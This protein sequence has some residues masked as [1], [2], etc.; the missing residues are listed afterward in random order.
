M[1]SQAPPPPSLRQRRHSR[2][3]LALAVL[4]VSL[5]VLVVAVVG[6]GWWALRSERGPAFVLSHVPG[7]SITGL[8]GA[9]DGGPLEAARV[10]WRHGGKRLLIEGLAWRDLAWQWRP[11]PGVWIGVALAEPRARRVEWTSGPPPPPAPRK[12]PPASLAL[13][14]ELA[15]QGLRVDALQ[16]D[17]LPLVSDLQLDAHLGADSGRR[18]TV[19][20]LALRTDRAQLS[21]RAGVATGGAQEVQAQLD[22]ASPAGTTPAWT[23]Q[24]RAAG[25][26][27]R[28]Q[29]E[30]TLRA[31]LASGAKAGEAAADVRATVTPFAAWPLAALEARTTDL[32]L[33]L[34]G[35]ALPHTRLTGR[36]LVRSSAADAPIEV[37]LD[38]ANALPGRWDQQR[39]PLRSGQFALRGSAAARERLELTRLDV[40]LGGSRPAGRIGGSGQWLADRA[41]LELRLDA[42][43]PRELDL[44]AAAM[45]VSGPL[46]L[47]L[48]GLPSPAG[49]AAPV[50]GRLAGETS[51]ELDGRI[52]RRG[53]PPVRL[54]AV[55]AFEQT[56]QALSLELRRLDASAAGARAGG[57]ASARRD[58]AGAWTV[59]SSGTLARFD[60]LPW[61]PGVG[62]NA[63]Q[64]G[65]HAL[66]GGWNADLDIAPGAPLAALRGRADLRIDASRLAGVALQGRVGFDGDGT[67]ARLDADLQAAAN[68]A[69]IEGRVGR[70]AADDRWRVDLQAPALAALAPWATLFDAAGAWVPQAG[71]ANVQAEA[72]GRWPALRSTGRAQVAGLRSRALNAQ[73]VDARW[74]VAGGR[75]DAPLSVVLE[76]DAVAHGEQ[77]LD[78]LRAELGGS[79]AA[80]TLALD[81]STPLR[82]PA[83]S[84]ALVGGAAVDGTTLAL[85]GRG[86]WSP[87]RAGGGTWRGQVARI[88][89]VPRRA[90]ATPQGAAWVAARELAATV[91]LDSAGA[92]R[93]AALAPGRLELLGAALTWREAQW[94]RGAAAGAP[95]RLALDAALEPLA[96]APWLTRLQPGFGWGGDLALRGS[97]KATGGERFSADLVLE[98]AGGDLTVTDEGGTQAL[99]LTDLRLGMVANDGTWH[100]TQA[101]AGSN[102]GVLGGA[103]SLRVPPQAVWPAPETPLEGVVEL[104]VANLGVWA[105]WVPPGWRLG[106]QLRM[107]ASLGG[108]F[109]APEYTGELVGSQLA[110]RNLLQGVDV[111]EG[112]L[113]VRLRGADAR[114]ERFAFRGGEGTL[115]LDG[116]ASFGTTPR[117]QLKMVA[118]RFQLL[119]RVDRR[120][121]VSGDAALAL[122]AK[123]IELDGRFR[124]DEGLVDVAQSDAPTLD[125]DVVVVRR[126][127]VTQGG[128]PPPQAPP[129]PAAQNPLR[130]AKV[131]LQVDLGNALRLRGRGLDTL[132]RGELR[133]STPG[134]NLAINGTVRTEAGTYMAYGEKLLIERGFVS[135]AGAANNPRLDILAV[136]PNMDVRVGVAVQGLAQS[137][138]VRLFS[139]PEMSELDKLSYLVMGRGSEGL[140]RTDTALLQRAAV[141]LLAGNDGGP[142]RSDALIKNIGLDELSLRQT[143]T[144]EVRDTVVSLGK[145]ISNRWYVGYERGVNATTGTWQLIYRIA[146]RFTLRAQSGA[147]NSLDVIWSWRWN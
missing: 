125:R 144:G 138:Q 42:V 120:I 11:R 113:A 80:H 115:R 41:Q 75:A 139:E 107:S 92:L 30:S 78:R 81:A 27:A 94:Q 121:V 72:Q 57:T 100:F 2:V 66:N 50:P 102:V 32:D 114:I 39:L 87:E 79:L 34:F 58:A 21:A 73:R 101:V 136:R 145:Q 137:P 141:A 17:A 134:G 95:A 70:S 61:W 44:R 132:L 28:L 130:N 60:P 84:D 119:G 105:T 126:S 142:S 112:D 46:R 76:A 124:V 20:R 56:A 88:D 53:A 71:T 129:V 128:T 85:R 33:G 103:Q 74:N 90:G 10:E 12:P 110:V 24:A 29:V 55:A 98:R 19:S 26:L 140:G 43:R 1:A 47:A 77:R 16:V 9:L 35:A 7:L 96:V 123:D 135:F 147:E 91:V 143:E 14:V 51:T 4:L 122:Q 133:V 3:A 37:D 97:F 36:A 22:A 48:E 108:R 86:A 65:P 82:P 83:W 68:R 116:G 89:A 31:Q 59:R 104:R 109:G 62:G 25:P 93:S 13:P 6:T 15:V 18:H 118:E 67:A 54:A 49:A 117:A 38:I 106:G 127:G 63:W 99:G 5:T 8:R 40:Q 52:D 23:A 131:A 45:T 64:R 146:Q 69:R 111:R